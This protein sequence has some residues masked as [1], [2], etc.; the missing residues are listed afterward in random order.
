[1]KKDKLVRDFKIYNIIMSQVWKFLTTIIIGVLGGYLV[2]RKGEENNNY[3]VII[4]IIAFIIGIIN[5][6]VGILKE[7]N[8]MV[9]REEMKKRLEEKQDTRNEETE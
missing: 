9:K 2:S 1:M 3:M 7:H 8:K 4:I 6:F 5:F